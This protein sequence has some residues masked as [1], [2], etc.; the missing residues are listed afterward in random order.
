MGFVGHVLV[1]STIDHS[2]VPIPFSKNGKTIE[3]TNAI[4]CIIQDSNNDIWV[5][6]EFSG[7]FKYDQD[8]KQLNY[9]KLPYYHENIDN[10]RVL[11]EDNRKILWIG[12]DGAGLG[13]LDLGTGN[14]SVYQHSGNDPFSLSNNTVYTISQSSEGIIWV[15][16]YSGGINL[17]NDKRYKFGIIQYNPFKQEGLGNNNV[18]TLYEDKE[19]IIWLGTRNGLDRYDPVKDVFKHYYHKEGDSHSISSNIVLSILEDS[20]GKLWVGTFSGGLNVLDK[21]SGRFEHYCTNPTDNTSI[22]NNNI[23]HIFEDS[24]RNL[25]I[26]TLSQLNKFNRSDGTFAKYPVSGIRYIFEDSQKRFYIG[27][28]YG[29][30]LFDPNAGSATKIWPSGSRGYMVPFIYEDTKGELWVATKGRGVLRY[31]AE[32]VLKASYTVNNG[33]PNDVINTIVEDDHGFLWLSTNK[34]ICKFDPVTEEIRS[35]DYGDGLQGNEFNTNSGI[36]SKNGLI[37]FGG[38]NGLNY[39]YPNQI[40]DNLCIPQVLLTNLKISNQQV[41]IG[42]EKSP[43]KTNISISKELNLKYDQSDFTFEF[44]ALNYTFPGKNQYAYKLEGFE[45]NWNYVGNKRSATYTNIPAGEYVFRVKASN[46]DMVWNDT[47]ASIEIFITPPFWR[48]WY[49]I[50]FYFAV[51]ISL[52]LMFKRYALIP[53]EVKNKLLIQR[54]ENEKKEELNQLKLAFFTNISHEFRTPLTLVVGPLEKMLKNTPGNSANRQQI[55]LML[56]NSKR[57]LMMVNQ[58]MDFRKIDMD[59][60]QLKLKQGDI[61]VFIKE[62]WQSFESLARDRRINYSFYSEKNSI[63]TWFDS[64]AIEKVVYNLLSNAFK[65]TSEVSGEISVFL[66]IIQE[67]EPNAKIGWLTKPKDYFPSYLQ[68][69][70][71]DNG[72]GIEKD[73]LHRIFDRFYVGD[74]MHSWKNEG[75][76]IGLALAKSFVE[77]HKGKIW[78]ESD[79]GEGSRFYVKIPIIP[80]PF[81]A[82]NARIT[83]E[84]GG[85]KE[86]PKRMPDAEHYKKVSKEESELI[87]DNDDSVIVLIVEDNPDLLEFIKSNMKGNYCFLDAT[88]GQEGFDIALKT[89]PDIVIS[90]VMMPVMDGLEF[91][92]KLKSHEITSHIPVILLTA[93]ASKEFKMEGFKTGADDYITK[94]FDPD[95]LESRMINL[96]ESRMKLKEL[97]SK[98]ITLEPTQTIITSQD[99]KL[100]SKLMETIDENLDNSEFGVAELVVKLGT[101]RAVLYRKVKALTNMSVIEFI[102]TYKL[103]KAAQF[104]SQNN[105]S[106][107]EIAYAVGYS[108]P[109]YFSKSFKEVFNISPKEYA[110]QKVK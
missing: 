96:L 7:L 91:C 54:I 45:D 108:D 56:R 28:S 81:E 39:F 8:L 87:P 16:N 34:G 2:T 90:D 104:L 31:S 13:K 86:H 5:A 70:V 51:I 102:K 107:A 9:Y 10:V 33:L 69:I 77:L 37:Y 17:Y 75:T 95:L 62:I 4:K 83:F 19:G 72:I 98:E 50:L 3:V 85:G 57:L 80:E 26:G 29:L 82:N 74:N 24:S 63:V 93:R 89:V 92:S 76:G 21:R 94:P 38:V 64:D 20:Y 109:K 84:E 55:E 23:Y 32:R 106:I 88:N 52:L 40:Q 100:L 46:N 47:G 1:Y 78:S 53:V 58:L 30:Y 73:K 11:F 25:W 42:E 12:F 15:G 79:I 36:K 35:Y 6:T 44:V 41:G 61:C 110:A 65:F 48:T 14:F 67:P 68:L 105:L 101:S 43:L 99:E 18:R 27:S 103:K 71:K 60:M 22:S 49:A 97:F 59:K 66:S